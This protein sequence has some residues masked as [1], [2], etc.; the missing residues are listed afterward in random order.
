MSGNEAKRSE[1]HAIINDFLDQGWKSLELAWNDYELQL[2]KVAAP[3]VEASAGSPAATHTVPEPTPNSSAAIDAPPAEQNDAAS[4]HSDG[5]GVVVTAPMMGTFYISPSPGV[6][7]FVEAGSD[8]VE[9]QSLCIVEVMKLMTRVESEVSGVITAI[10]AENGQL[11]LEGD[12]LFTIA[13]VG[14]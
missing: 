14:S 11:V 9:G 2:K 3:A 1:I 13:P 10:H 8:V 7:P 6:A 4:G 5:V 12:P